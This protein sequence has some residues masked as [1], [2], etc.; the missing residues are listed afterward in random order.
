M[1][2]TLQ[3]MLTNLKSV[4]E[5]NGNPS[6]VDGLDKVLAVMAKASEGLQKLSEAVENQVASNKAA[7]KIGEASDVNKTLKDLLEAQV[8]ADKI[9]QERHNR[10]M[11]LAEKVVPAVTEEQVTAFKYQQLVYKEHQKTLQATL[12]IEKKKALV[13]TQAAQ[14]MAKRQT[15]VAKKQMESEL[16]RI[17]AARAEAEFARSDK[18]GTI[19]GAIGGLAGKA[20]DPFSKFLVQGLGRWVKE[21]K[22]APVAKSIK[23]KY[24]TEEN[25]VKEDFDTQSKRF[26]TIADNKKAMAEAVY[27]RKESDIKEAFALDAYKKGIKDPGSAIDLYKNR[28]S[29]V[30]RLANLGISAEAGLLNGD[31]KLLGS[32]KTSGGNSGAASVGGTERSSGNVLASTKPGVTREFARVPNQRT[33]PVTPSIQRTRGQPPSPIASGA[34]GKFGGKGGFID[35]GGISKS[36]L[37][38]S[39]NFTKFLG[40]WGMAANALMSLDKLVPIISTGSGALMDLTKMLIPM[41]ISGLIEGFATLVQG[42]NGLINVIDNA[43]M[44]GAKW[45]QKNKDAIRS[46]KTAY[47]EGRENDTLNN[48]IRAKEARNKGFEGAGII[49]T[50]TQVGGIHVTKKTAPKLTDPIEKSTLENASTASSTTSNVDSLVSSMAELPNTLASMQKSVLDARLQPTGT[51]PITIMPPSLAGW[52]V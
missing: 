8:A 49:D 34:S 5:S 23:D 41:G 46:S 44:I 17:S 14:D 38:I 29:Q 15:A 9:E 10:I 11:N 39:K 25:K 40:P 50:T 37:G 52:V 36:I 48:R 24:D 4:S 12:D 26:Q 18:F 43:P 45:T 3:D 2:I 33:S 51:T 32:P 47:V 13:Q 27:A 19:G 7:S 6:L 30:A 42:I 31:S 35:L 16:E 22:E 21:R 1:A 28:D 20:Q